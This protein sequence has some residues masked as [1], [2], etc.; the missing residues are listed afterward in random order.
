MENTLPKPIH[1]VG[2]LNYNNTPV[3]FHQGETVISSERVRKAADLVN[4][5]L[6]AAVNSVHHRILMIREQ[7]KELWLGLDL[8][9]S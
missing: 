1:R 8:A 3:R 4:M 2:L 7:T 9:L 5:C 6:A